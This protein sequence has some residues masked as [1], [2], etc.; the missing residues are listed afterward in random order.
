V[1]KGICFPN[2]TILANKRSH[3]I[4]ISNLDRETVEHVLFFCYHAKAVGDFIL[5]VGPILR[6]YWNLL[7]NK[8]FL[9]LKINMFKTNWKSE[10]EN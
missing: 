8:S 7:V 2:G 5:K 6:F 4:T 3:E 1:L 10:C 9:I